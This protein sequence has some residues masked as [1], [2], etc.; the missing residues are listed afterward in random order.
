MPGLA[1]VAEASAEFFFLGGVWYGEIEEVRWYKKEGVNKTSH[2]DKWSKPDI[3]YMCLHKFVWNNTW[4]SILWI[5]IRWIF[6][7]SLS[8]HIATVFS[9]AIHS[10]DRGDCTTWKSRSKGCTTTTLELLESKCFCKCFQNLAAKWVSKLQVIVYSDTWKKGFEV[11]VVFQQACF[12]FK[13]LLSRSTWSGS[14]QHSTLCYE[15]MGASGQ[16]WFQF[17]AFPNGFS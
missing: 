13:A 9:G 17:I 1:S 12:F 6:Q 15:L 5:V 10:W 8:T 2:Q 7:C 14:H 11:I 16:L 3:Y 4:I